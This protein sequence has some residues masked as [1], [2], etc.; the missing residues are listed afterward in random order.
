M[1]NS[2]IAIIGGGASGLLC[3]I[4]AARKNKNKKIIIIEKESRVGKKLLAT[5]N[6]RCNLTNTTISENNYSGSFSSEINNTFSEFTSDYIIKYFESIGIICKAD[7]EG[8]VY[9]LSDQAS[10]V[11]DLIRT[12]L[13]HLNVEEH[14]TM[15]VKSITNRNNIFQINCGETTFTAKKIVIA[16]GGKSTPNLGSDGSGFMLLKQLGIRVNPTYPGLAPIKCS[17]SY[18]KSLKGVR[19][20]C[21]VNLIAD[22][23]IIKKEKGELQFTENALSGICIYNLSCFINEL[24]TKKTVNGE[25]KEAIYISVDLF[26]D[27]SEDQL[28]KFLNERLKKF[29]NFT[30]ENYLTGV[31]NKRLHS[32]V[33]KQLNIQ[34]YEQINADKIAGLLKKWRFTPIK[35][36]DYFASQVTC[37]GVGS[38]E[39]NPK[40]MESKKVKNLYIIG[41]A[42]DINGDCGGYNLHWA[43][44]S[45]ILAGENL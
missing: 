39:I 44:S 25:K 41:E 17:E 35:I 12:E 34:S 26:P 8:R 27:F 14:C 45:G 20:K 32:V 42:V 28:S 23:K 36:S 37:G 2:D 4:A 29:P 43:F 16:S 6:G 21:E 38:D 11:L 10:S 19:C 24:L 3:G 40:T 15:T 18:L 7:S 31:I 1:I 30:L 5:G 22:N 9:P 13:L 33:F